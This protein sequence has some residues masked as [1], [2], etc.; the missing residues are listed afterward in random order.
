VYVL[1]ISQLQVVCAICDDGFY[2]TTSGCAEC[3]T[4]ST[5]SYIVAF[6]VILFAGVVLLVLTCKKRK[7]IRTTV[8]K[9]ARHVRTKADKYAHFIKVSLAILLGKGLACRTYSVV[10]HTPLTSLH[11]KNRFSPGSLSCG[12]GK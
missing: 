8:A 3:A 10:E 4:T 2:M 6:G 9:G 7:Q 12:C 5:T 1:S 11:T